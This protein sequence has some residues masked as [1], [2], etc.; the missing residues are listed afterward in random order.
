MHKV[1]SGGQTAIL[2]LRVHVLTEHFCLLAHQRCE[3]LNKYRK[4]T[5]RATAAVPKSHARLH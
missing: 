1:S 4:R 2:Q 3:V 5:D